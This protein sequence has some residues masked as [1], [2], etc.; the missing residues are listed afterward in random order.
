MV[1]MNLINILDKIENIKKAGDLSTEVI[2]YTDGEN[3]LDKLR[4]KELSKKIDIPIFIK[5][6]K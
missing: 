1:N 5:I 3:I 4:E 2:L 6:I